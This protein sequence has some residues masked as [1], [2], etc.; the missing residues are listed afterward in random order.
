MDWTSRIQRA[1]GADVTVGARIGVGGFAEVYEGTDERLGRRIAIKVLREDIGAPRARERFMREA[2]AAAQLRHQNVLPVFDVG[3][4]D[5]ISWFTM[6]LVVGESLRTRLD[7]VQRMEADDVVRIVGAAA[8]GLHAAHRAGLVHRDVKPDNIM[9]DGA[10]SHVYIADFGIAAAAV[11]DGDRL[12]T[13]GAVIGTPRYMSPEQAAGEPKID[14]RTDVYSLGVVA[15]EMLCGEPPFMAANAGALLAKHL[16][17]PVPPIRDRASRCPSAVAAAVERAL[18]KDP[19]D[20]WPT[21]EAFRQALEGRVSSQMVRAA[22][23]ASAPTVGGATSRRV[24]AIAVSAVVIA[25][26]ADMTRGS[27]LASPLAV[28]GATVALAITAGTRYALRAQRSAAMPGAMAARGLRRAR[29]LRTAVRALLVS[30]PKV[31][32]ARLGEAELILDRLL[33]EAEHASD[34]GQVEGVERATAAI[35]DIHALVEGTA[36]GEGGDVAARLAE[37]TSHGATP[38][39]GADAT[40]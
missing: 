31:E 3:E 20:R 36:S 23:D 25:G 11:P 29:A 21:A 28:L 16:T 18:E 12:T 24:I 5:Q 2:R 6:P 1:L 14:I 27:L 10:E 22:G 39:G 7:R 9:L 32:R 30:M 26:I 34:S 33:F 4:R 8:A 13:E 15:Y 37:I 19:L 17:A 40:R 38:R 35:K